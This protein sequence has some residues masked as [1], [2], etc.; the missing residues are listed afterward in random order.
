M[1]RASGQKF[2]KT[3]T[4]AVYLDAEMTSPYKFYQ[5]WINVDDRDVESYLKLFTLQ[6]RAEIDALMA[7][8]TRNPAPRAAQ[9]ALATDVT[10]RVHGADTVKGVVNASAILFGEA[11]SRGA[12]PA[13]FEILAQEIPTATVAGET[14]P[15]VDAVI[16]AGLAK[17]KNEARRA[18]E[19]GGIYLNQER[20]DDVTRR[21]GPGDWIAGRNALLRKGKKE[22]ALLRREG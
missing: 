2:G 1:T 3:E 16:T 18:I 11:E 12:D 22:Y 9:R 4:G 19:Q 17:S 15:L 5:F 7:E 13:V 14:A 6:S 21:L 10:T 20:I 8:H